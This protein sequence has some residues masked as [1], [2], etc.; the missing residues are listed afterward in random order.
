MPAGHGSDRLIFDV[1]AKRGT[2]TVPDCSKREIARGWCTKH[3]N[4]WLKHG[5]ANHAT[6]RWAPR[7]TRCRH[8]GCTRECFGG[9]RGWCSFHYSR[10]RTGGEEALDR[11]LRVAAPVRVNDDGYRL[12]RVGPGKYVMEHR[13]V[14]GEVLGRPLLKN[15]NVHHRNG[16]KDDNRPENLELW[17]TIQPSGQ[18]V[19][20]LL[21]FAEEIL[22]RYSDVP[23]GV[24]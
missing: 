8:D 4:R 1:T 6:R 19:S 15:E 18:R 13:L 24:L 20:D 21:A 5:D 14:M 12:V 22:A 23:I 10:W 17:A 16:V 3:Y 7:G 11:P 9:G 2:C